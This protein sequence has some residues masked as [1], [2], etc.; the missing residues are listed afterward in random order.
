MEQKLFL[1]LLDLPKATNFRIYMYTSTLYK[2]RTNNTL[3]NYTLYV[4]I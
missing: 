2:Y 4:W 1:L 3:K